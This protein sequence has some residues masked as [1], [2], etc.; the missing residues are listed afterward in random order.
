MNK[1]ILYKKSYTILNNTSALKRHARF[2]PYSFITGFLILVLMGCSTKKNTVMTRNYHNLTSHYNVYFNAYEIKR[3]AHKKIE[4]SYQDDFNSFLPIDIYTQKEVARRLLPDMDKVIKKC[5]KVITMHSITAKPKRKSRGRMT[6]KQR[7]FS[8]KNEF[9][10]WIDDAYFLMGQAYYLKHDRFP[11]IQN[12]EYVIKQFPED[13][14]KQDANLW[15]AKTHLALNDYNTSKDI[16]DRLEADPELPDRLKG[17]IAALWADWYLAQ[18][19]YDEAIAELTE[20]ARLT[21]DKKKLVRYAYLTAQLLEKEEDFAQASLKYEEVLSLGPDYR[22]AFNAKINRAKL[23]EGDSDIGKEIR[24]QL[25]KMLRDDKNIEFLDQVYYA[26][27][28]LDMKEGLVDAAIEKYKL[29]AQASVDNFHQKSLSYLALGKIYYARPEYLS[30]Q[31]YYDSCL[32]TL[33]E[34]FDNRIAVQKLGLSLNILAENLRLIT[35]EDS[36]QAVAA[37][38]EDEREALIKIKMDEAKAAEEARKQ[39]EEEERQNGRSGYRMAGGSGRSGGPGGLAMAPGSMNQGSGMGDGMGGGMDGS[40]MSNALAGANSQ[41]YFY[42]PTTLSYGQAEFSKRFGRRKLED[43]WRRSNKGISSNMGDLST[44]G[45]E[46]DINTPSV[47]SNAGQFQ[48]TQR[49]YYVADLPLNDTLIAESNERIQGALFNVGKVFKDELKK[50]EEA[51]TYFETLLARF[52]ETDRLLFTYY[53]L[54]QVFKAN[55]NVERENYYKDLILSRFPESRSAKII[56]NPNYF[57][58]IEDARLKVVGF[59]KDTYE[60]FKAGLYEQV[61]SN[62]EKADTAFGLNQMRDKFGLLKVMSMAALD[63]EN[64]AVLT[65]RLNDLI[66]KYPESEVKETAGIMLAYLENGPADLSKKPGKSAGLSIGKVE[67]AV[68]EE[69]ADYVFEEE[70]VH[71]YVAVVSRRSQ[72]LNR[73][74]FNISNFNVEN[75]DQDFF[76]VASTPMNEDL[77]I[78]TVKNFPNLKAGMDYYHAL[79]ADPQVFTEFKETDFRHFII[80]RTNYNLFYKN[81]NVFRYIQFFNENYLSKEQ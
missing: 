75:Y 58:E 10:K 38:P 39:L 63:P 23:Y 69:A 71:F 14:L 2:A 26:L 48:P 51:V 28:E 79:L 77:M 73:L 27:A 78:I 22:M 55:G 5:S 43:N 60:D 1:I 34:T 21:K 3:E 76:E 54:Y 47:K 17:D 66:F 65:N 56:S 15:L 31:I 13:G 18:N 68:E 24:K 32:L 80:S 44:E 53:N 45:E 42:N 8:K 25:E 29:S 70:T 72:D 7:E 4:S 11:A 19:Q 59:Y 16:L 37:M 36:L 81:K 33:P 49:D 35:R 64:K 67:Q 12:F 57:K 30:A 6:E 50:E 9:N 40:G 61:I 46:G 41:W 52:P 20:A 74:N 62:C